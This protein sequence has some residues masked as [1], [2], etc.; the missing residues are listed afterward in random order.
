MFALSAKEIVNEKVWVTESLR[1]KKALMA[2]RRKVEILLAAFLLS[3]LHPFFSERN[4]SPADDQFDHPRKLIMPTIPDSNI[5]FSPDVD[6]PLFPTVCH[7]YIALVVEAKQ[8]PTICNPDD[9][10]FIDENCDW[11]SAKYW[12]QWWTRST[13]L[14]MLSRVLAVCP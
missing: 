8:H 13:H 11:T 5:H 6:G 3:P 12:A 10:K 4:S 9:A 14:K 7:C 2:R 1:D